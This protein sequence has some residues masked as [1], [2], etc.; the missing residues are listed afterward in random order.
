MVPDPLL[1]LS[2]FEKKFTLRFIDNLRDSIV[3]SGRNSPSSK[4]SDVFLEDLNEPLVRAM[5]FLFPVWLDLVVGSNSTDAFVDGLTESVEGLEERSTEW[6]RNAS[7]SPAFSSHLSPDLSSDQKVVTTMDWIRQQARFNG[8]PTLSSSRACLPSTRLMV[9]PSAPP[10]DELSSDEGF[11]LGSGITKLWRRVR[12]PLLDVLRYS[13]STY[14][15][16]HGRGQNAS[17]QS[18]ILFPSSTIGSTSKIFSYNG[19]VVH[20]NEEVNLILQSFGLHAIES[21]LSPILGIAMRCLAKLTPLFLFAG[22][23]L[24]VWYCLQDRQFDPAA[25][26]KELH[27]SSPTSSAFTEASL[28]LPSAST[29]FP[30]DCS[31]KVMKN[32]KETTTKKGDE[33]QTVSQV[34]TDGWQSER[35]VIQELLDQFDK[36]CKEC[37]VLKCKSDPA[38]NCTVRDLHTPFG[39]DERENCSKRRFAFSGEDLAGRLSPMYRKQAHTLIS[40]ATSIAV[41][42][43]NSKL[44]SR[45]CKSSRSVLSVV[46]GGEEMEVSGE[47]S[48]QRSPDISRTLEES[49]EEISAHGMIAAAAFFDAC[50]FSYSS[51]V[52]EKSVVG[53]QSDANTILS[54]KQTHFFPENKRETVQVENRISYTMLAGILH[55]YVKRLAVEIDRLPEAI[56]KEKKA[57][58]TLVDTSTTRSMKSEKSVPSGQRRSNFSSLGSSGADASSSSVA[59]LR[60]GYLM[61]VALQS[62]MSSCVQ[63]P[64]VAADRGGRKR[65]RHESYSLWSNEKSKQWK[66][67]SVRRFSSITTKGKLGR[68]KKKPWGLRG[69]ESEEDEEESSSGDESDNFSDEDDYDRSLEEQEEEAYLP[70]G[71]KNGCKKSVCRPVSSVL[72]TSDSAQQRTRHLLQT[73]LK[74]HSIVF[75]SSVLSLYSIPDSEYSWN[76]S[77]GDLFSVLSFTETQ[78]RTGSLEYC[79]IGDDAVD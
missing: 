48:T 35:E 31:K 79:T 5:A 15:R 29:S 26:K 66:S 34:R 30:V 71:R 19:D 39:L 77:N 18:S 74:P 14:G 20:S 78:L 38:V 47:E 41:K 27:F 76:A 54:R 17:Q 45:E 12:L 67:T 1:S 75:A 32:G 40:G 46:Q 68:R 36:E 28:S 72:S 60:V 8:H 64:G 6:R 55:T 24:A 42:T 22:C 23:L 57:V 65:G 62:P 9:M 59:P 51:R 10:S 4:S 58:N 37:L 63:P 52:M 13:S 33:L 69:K 3:R 56:Q 49:K 2:G 73:L 44:L 25:V 70:H 53:S 21:S 11:L 61:G 43:E 7:K 16:Q 50:F